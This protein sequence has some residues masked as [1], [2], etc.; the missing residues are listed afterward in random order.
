[1]STTKFTRPTDQGNG[2]IG[3][4]ISGVGELKFM[5]CCMTHAFLVANVMRSEQ[6]NLLLVEPI[7]WVRKSEETTMSGWM[8]CA[9]AC[10][11]TSSINFNVLLIYFVSVQIG[12]E[13]TPTPSYVTLSI[14]TVAQ[15][16]VSAAWKT[17]TYLFLYLFHLQRSLFGFNGLW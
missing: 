4:L 11:K 8:Q 15:F 14:S 12:N 17:T 1:M 5:P 6:S 3:W 7:K 10:T 16:S 2:Q 9:R 13:T